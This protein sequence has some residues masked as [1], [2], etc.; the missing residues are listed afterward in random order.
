MNGNTDGTRGSRRVWLL[1]CLV[2]VVFLM[3]ACG[4]S[5]SSNPTASSTS[6]SSTSSTSTQTTKYQKVLAFSQC[7]RAHGVSD[8]PDPNVNG[9]ISLSSL[10]GQ[11]NLNSTQVSSAIQ[12]CR[13]LLPNGGTLNPAQQQKALTALLKFS[14]CM[15]AHGVPNFPDP[16]LVDGKVSLDLK[17]T[18]I[19]GSTPHIVTASATCRSVLPKGIAA[20]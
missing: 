2:G 9:A 5:A 15:R 10:S 14:R 17:G 20:S 7:V 4:S 3:T 16:S 19:S 13:H 12:A 6:T 11:S 1:T 18:G 8:F